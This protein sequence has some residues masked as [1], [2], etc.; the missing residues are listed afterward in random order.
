[1]S[2]FK[3]KITNMKAA[4]EQQ[5]DVVRQLKDL[6]NEIQQVQRGLSFEIAQKERIRQR[7]KTVQSEVT[8]EYT[9]INKAVKTL[10]NIANVYETTEAKLAGIEVPKR[11]TMTNINDV[12]DYISDS[13]SI[14]ILSGITAGVGAGVEWGFDKLVSI[15][16]SKTKISET[17]FDARDEKSNIWKEK[18]YSK[19]K[20]DLQDSAIEAFK[21]ISKKWA[22]SDTWLQMEETYG[23]KDGTHVS[24]SLD[25][26]KFSSYAQMY[27]G[28]YYID[29]ETGEKRLN[30]AIGA[31]AGFTFSA[32]TAQQQMQ[33]GNDFLG[34]YLTTEETFGRVS[35]N[36]SIVA[37]F[38][39]ADGN[40]NPTIHGNLSAEAILA[41]VSAK[42]G[43][44]V[45]GTDVG[46]KGSVNVGV[47]AHAEFGFKDGKFSM[48]V[49]ASLGI[50]GSV[51]LEIDFS[52]TIDAIASK[53]KAM[54]PSF[55]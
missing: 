47:G 19:N 18:H 23:D 10:D 6:K 7:L 1:M 40:F 4:V 46:V 27:A 41:E 14:G 32:L 17:L 48:D 26:L 24:Q 5:N 38:R 54:W 12:I 42:G 50:G 11:N 8:K 21:L 2:E 45:L 25:M 43:V 15:A 28:L 33:L 37:G 22:F 53:A 31:E 34:A 16:K 13:G 9:G 30:P 52:D 20:K 44:K 35:A 55:W 29:K 36:G 49:G 3:V 39:D 51:K